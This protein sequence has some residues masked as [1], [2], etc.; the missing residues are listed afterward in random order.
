M[1]QLS[2]IILAGFV[3]FVLGAYSA[4]LGLSGFALT[5]I[6]ILLAAILIGLTGLTWQILAFLLVFLG[7]SGATYSIYQ[8]ARPSV[9]SPLLPKRGDLSKE[10]NVGTVDDVRSKFMTTPGT[11]FR[12]YVFPNQG[13]KSNRLTEQILLKFGTTAELVILPGGITGQPR[14][15]LRV[16]TQGLTTS[17]EEIPVE[18]LPSQKWTHVAIV[19]EG[20][21][22]TVY[23]NGVIVASKRLQYYPVITS[24][25]LKIG[26]AGFTGE[27]ALPS[28]A[29]TSLTMLEIR[30]DMKNT[31]DTRHKPNSPTEMFEFFQVWKYFTCPNGIFCFSTSAPPR[32][33][34][35]TLWTT[36]YA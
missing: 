2:S 1:I 26:G 27:F 17:M 11:T 25:N 33:D 20:R 5:F 34:P 3:I 35:L 10:T 4:Y 24:G 9:Q 6:Y 18:T 13:D 28:L 31:S 22:F 8:R 36:S 12:V 14:T 15:V 30:D 23:Y 19:R 7:L 32:T 16:K 29:P 21:R